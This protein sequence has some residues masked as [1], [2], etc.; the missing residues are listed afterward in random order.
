MGPRKARCHRIPVIPLQYIAA[1]PR[2]TFGGTKVSVRGYLQTANT[3]W[4]QAA[5]G[6]RG[7]FK[8]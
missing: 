5:E 7:V 8:G 1:D 6:A 2:F 3:T 4:K